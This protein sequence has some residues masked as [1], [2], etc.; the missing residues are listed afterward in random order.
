MRSEHFTD[1]QKKKNP[2]KTTPQCPK[3]IPHQITNLIT[4]D[5]TGKLN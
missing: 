4:P 5:P 2:T 3:S 1:I